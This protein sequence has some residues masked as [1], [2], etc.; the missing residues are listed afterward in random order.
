MLVM[1]TDCDERWVAGGGYQRCEESICQ[2]LLPVKY[3]MAK[4]K[5]RIPLRGQ[6]RVAILLASC[7]SL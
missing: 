5:L 7:N 3:W 1:V 2:M 6:R 4:R